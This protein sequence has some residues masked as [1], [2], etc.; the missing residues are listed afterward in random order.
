M[1]HQSVDTEELDSEDQI[2][3]HYGDEHRGE[4]FAL[5]FGPHDTPYRAATATAAGT[6]STT[7]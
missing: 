4:M 7:P 2:A 1:S 5:R 3:V 6:G